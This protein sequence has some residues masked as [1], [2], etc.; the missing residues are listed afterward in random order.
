M[1]ARRFSGPSLSCAGSAPSVQSRLVAFLPGGGGGGCR[2][3]GH[4]GCGRRSAPAR[5]SP[6][7]RCGKNRPEGRGA[8]TRLH[9]R[10][11]PVRRGPC[12]Y[13]E[14]VHRAV[15]GGEGGARPGACAA[16]SLGWESVK[17]QE[18]ASRCTSRS[19]GAWLRD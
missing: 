11:R 15:R 2:R 1:A 17:A 9:C 19:G 8:T 12:V 14:K 10:H 13:V 3:L 4:A 6:G 16:G 7:T 5:A 18:D